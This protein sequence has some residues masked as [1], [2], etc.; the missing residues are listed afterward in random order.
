VPAR[1]KIPTQLIEGKVKIILP[2]SKDILI[3]KIVLFNFHKRI[4]NFLHC[5]LKVNQL[6]IFEVKTGN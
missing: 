3:Q 1:V 6:D 5:Q 2:F 4:I